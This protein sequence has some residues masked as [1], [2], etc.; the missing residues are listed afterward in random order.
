ATGRFTL[1]CLPTRQLDCDKRGWA[2]WKA[3]CGKCRYQ[4]VFSFDRSCGYRES[5]A[6]TWIWHTTRHGSVPVGH[7]EGWS[8]SRSAY[9]SD[10][11]QSVSCQI[12]QWSR[13]EM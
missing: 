6:S 4:R 1:S 5:A 13:G 3:V 10:V 12:R 7:I 8:T 9:Q 11:I 2:C